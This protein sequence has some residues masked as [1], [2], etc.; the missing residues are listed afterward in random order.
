M[1]KI[2]ISIVFLG[3]SNIALAVPVLFERNYT[4]HAWGYVNE[5]CFVD[6]SGFVYTYDVNS[7]KAME[8]IARVSREEL[9]LGRELLMKA[10]QGQFTRKIVAADAGSLLYSGK[11]WGKTIKLGESGDYYGVNDA[12]EAKKLLE[13]IK[14]WCNENL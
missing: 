2:I 13:L 9:E 10:S 14:G 3:L 4:N 7:G 1:K 8:E 5:G 11:L 6:E 12:P